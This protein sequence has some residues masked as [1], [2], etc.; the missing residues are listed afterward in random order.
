MKK[1][2]LHD[3]RSFLDLLTEENELLIIDED[4]DPYLEIAEI[5]RRVIANQGP[6]LLFKKVKNAS[7]PV[8]T[9]LFGT[10]NRLDLAFGTKPLGNGLTL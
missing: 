1:K 5:H 4:V 10:A 7:F 9:N 3:L 6:A 2:P 8:V